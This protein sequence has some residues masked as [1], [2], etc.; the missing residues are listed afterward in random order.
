M[1]VTRLIGSCAL[2]LFAFGVNAFPTG[3][4]AF[5]F[6]D[7]FG[8]KINVL[9]YQPI[10]FEKTSPIQFV[11]HGMSRNA[12]QTRENWIALAERAQVLVVAPEFDEKQFKRTNDY[13]L[14]GVRDGR[15]TVNSLLAIELL[16]DAIKKNTG[17]DRASYRIFGHSAGAQFVHRLLLLVPENRAEW[18]IASNAGR[19]TWPEWRAGKGALPLPNGL[20]NVEGA[21]SKLKMALGKNLIVMLGEADNDPNHGQLTH[22]KEVDQQGLERLSRGRNFFEAGQ[23]AAA[24]M[25]LTTKWM[26]KTVP[27]VGHDSAGMAQ[28][29]IALMYPVD[30]KP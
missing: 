8:H 6:D 20:L 25:K 14:G 30:L 13:S 18:A 27:N 11:M 21:E 23:T 17:S 26:L 12:A 7:G 16:F 5:D 28:A 3:K 22:G 1:N 4:S 10:K 29:A 9:V 19:Y 24:E 2:L 15:L